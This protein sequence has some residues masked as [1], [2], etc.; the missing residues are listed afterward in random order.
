MRY[1]E[2]WVYDAIIKAVR[3][4]GSH[5]NTIPCVV[6]NEEVDTTIVC[7]LGDGIEYWGNNPYTVVYGIWNSYGIFSL[8]VLLAARSYKYS[9]SQNYNSM[10]EEI[11]RHRDAFK[12][13]WGTEEEEDY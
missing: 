8:N 6:H 2:K 5:C 11:N 12:A 7:G 9:D 10:W 13:L 4:H 3:R 1:I